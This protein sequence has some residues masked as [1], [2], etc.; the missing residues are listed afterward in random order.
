MKQL[1]LKNCNEDFNIFDDL[2]IKRGFDY[3]KYH[4]W[5]SKEENCMTV[6]IYS[7]DG[8]WVGYQKYSP[9][10]DKS[11]RYDGRYHTWSSEQGLWGLETIPEDY[12]GT[13]YLTEAVFRSVALHRIGLQSVSLL[14]SS[15]SKALLREIRN[16]PKYKFVWIGD[17]PNDNFDAGKIMVNKIGGWQSPKDLDEM[18][19]EELI[20]MFRNK[21]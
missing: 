8:R 17:P 10:K 20:E 6:P 11:Y 4:C 9:L 19:S 15:C 2:L 16:H 13:V 21:E 7:F 14:G 18:T 1:N 3:R 5:I 12:N